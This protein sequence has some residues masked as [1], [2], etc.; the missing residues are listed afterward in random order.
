[1]RARWYGA[2]DRKPGDSR[3]FCER[4]TMWDDLWVAM[5]LMLVLEGIFPFLSPVRFKQVL[6]SVLQTDEHRL[7]VA[8]LLSMVAGVLLLY[9]AH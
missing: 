9:L 3:L 8:G 2:T 6:H 1:M 4:Q 7:R 5:A